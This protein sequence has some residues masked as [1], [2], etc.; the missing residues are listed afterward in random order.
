MTTHLR[1]RTI[2]QYLDTL[3]SPAPA[4]GG[5]SVAGLVGALAASLGQMV[6][7]LTLE[8]SENLLLSAAVNDLGHA[9]NDLLDSAAQD[10]TC[11]PGYLAAS[12]LPKS[13]DDE[14]ATRRQAMQDAMIYATEVPLGLAT[15]AGRV[16]EFLEPVAREGTPHATSDTAIGVN[17]AEAAVLAALSNVRSNIPLIKTPETAEDFT[18]R[19]NEVERRATHQAAIL[20]NI[21][22]AR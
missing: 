7:N 14:K 11:Y 18:A 22:A 12:R 1:N 3:A 19:A 6:A 9:A 2:G 13:T 21:L 5:G 10:E 17:L 15:S 4:P 16:L 8:R 20:R